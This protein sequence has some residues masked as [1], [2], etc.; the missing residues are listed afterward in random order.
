MI[1]IADHGADAVETRR[2]T[3]G[4][5]CGEFVVGTLRR[6]D[7]LEEGECRRVERLGGVK[8]TSKILLLAMLIE[9]VP[10]R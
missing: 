3:I 5:S 2:K 8:R 6:V 7:S 1:G 10:A 4:D 9:M